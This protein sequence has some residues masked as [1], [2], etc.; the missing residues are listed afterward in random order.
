MP[1]LSDVLAAPRGPNE[2]QKNG[3]APAGTQGCDQSLDLPKCRLWA[4]SEG[5]SSPCHLGRAFRLLR[6]P[7]GAASHGP[8]REG[9]PNSIFTPAGPAGMDAVPRAH[10][11]W[12][13]A[14]DICSPPP[15]L[16]LPSR[17]Q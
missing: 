17:V 14:V 9:G 4:H 3:R 15:R 2:M 13:D 12:R 16:C 5:P 10:L 8:G 6:N 11:A 1:G 7:S